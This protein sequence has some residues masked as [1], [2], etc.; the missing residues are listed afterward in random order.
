[1][2]EALTELAA[3]LNPAFE[4]H[5]A[6]GPLLIAMRAVG[7]VLDITI[8]PPKNNKSQVNSVETIAQ[9][10]GFRVRRITLD[11]VWWQQDYGPLLGFIATET[12]ERP[13]ALLPKNGRGY[14]IFDPVNFRRM[15]VGFATAKHLS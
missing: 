15:N 4:A 6:T 12:E 7:K 8:I 1:M 2:N 11:D 5:S 14:E 13:V 10:S 9:N 3:I